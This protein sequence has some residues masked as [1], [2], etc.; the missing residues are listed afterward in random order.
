MSATDRL[1]KN[2]TV[3]DNFINNTEGERAQVGHSL[4]IVATATRDESDN[5]VK[6]SRSPVWNGMR[7]M[8]RSVGRSRVLPG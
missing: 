5:P 3:A 8:A 4:S 7:P 1:V 2:I 6:G